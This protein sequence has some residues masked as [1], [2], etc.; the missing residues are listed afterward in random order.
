[1]CMSTFPT[2]PLWKRGAQLQTLR[3][4][5]SA[6]A[7]AAHRAGSPRLKSNSSVVVT[8][9]GVATRRHDT[10]KAERARCR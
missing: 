8:P 10:T 9:A 2:D 5:E 7:T 6:D 1:M 4:S 3:Y